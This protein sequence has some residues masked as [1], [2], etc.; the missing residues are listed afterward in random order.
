MFRRPSVN[1]RCCKNG[2]NHATFYL[3]SYLRTQSRTGRLLM[4]SAESTKSGTAGDSAAQT[5]KHPRDTTNANLQ[6]GRSGLSLSRQA[7]RLKG[8]SSGTGW[9]VAGGNHTEPSP[10]HLLGLSR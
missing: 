5:S 3:T 10:I 9:G 6:N 4:K 7:A 1:I 2:N 8:P